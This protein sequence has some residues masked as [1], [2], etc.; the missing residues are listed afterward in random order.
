MGR[1]I[2]ESWFRLRAGISSSNV[3]KA[4]SMRMVKSL[5][6]RRHPCL[7]LLNFFM[8]LVY[9]PNHLMLVSS[10]MQASIILFVNVL[11]VLVVRMSLSAFRSTVSKAFSISTAIT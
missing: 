8:G 3:C 9:W 10:F 1:V 6:D 11:L 2:S 4:S 7:N 5:G